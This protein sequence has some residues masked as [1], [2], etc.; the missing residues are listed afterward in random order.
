M[1]L[2]VNDTSL[3]DDP[4]RDDILTAIDKLDTEEFA[5]LI[6]DDSH[7]VQTRCNDDETWSL[8]YRDGSPEKHFGTDPDETTRV[9]ARDAFAAFFDGSDIASMLPWELVDSTPTEPGEGEVE[10]NGVIMDAEWPAQIEAAQAIK[11]ISISGTLYKR[12]S[13][14][15]EKDMPTRGLPNC[16]D[17]GAVQG[18][19]HVPDCDIE[20]CPKC[21]G[22][23]VSCDCIE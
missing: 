14:G 18:Q 2:N 7:F 1:E 4:A 12:I 21:F 17:C 23:L 11:T 6:R 15:R 3:R 8:E 22:Q 5:I 16:G 9:D 20:Q 13:F 19:L 10:Y